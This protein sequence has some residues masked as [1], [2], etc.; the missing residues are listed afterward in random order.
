MQIHIKMICIPHNLRMEDKLP[1]VLKFHAE[2][3]LPTLSFSSKL[4]TNKA[5][6]YT[7]GIKKP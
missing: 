3:L 1:R 6:A 7:F 5:S 4:T 2:K